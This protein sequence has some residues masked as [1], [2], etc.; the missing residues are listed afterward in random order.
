M[1]TDALL[2]FKNVSKAFG[3]VQANDQVSFSVQTG[4]IHALVGENGAGK[5]TIMKMLFGLYQR[6]RGQIFLN[7][8]SIEFES[9]LQAKRAGIGMVHQHFMLAGPLTALDHI[10]LDDFSFSS[11]LRPLPKKK[12][13]QVLESLSEKYG[14][15]VPWNEKIQNLSVGFQQRI[16]IL[17][18]LHKD[19]KI[20]ILDEPTAVLTPQEVKSL[21]EQLRQLKKSGHTILLITHK[22]KEVLELADEVSVFRQGRVI[23]SLPVNQTSALQLSEWM[24]GRKLMPLQRNASQKLTN[25]FEMKELSHQELKLRNLN[26]KIQGG[27][28][29]GIAGV[30]GNGQ[31]ELLQVLLNPRKFTELQGELLWRDQSLLSDSPSDLKNKGFSYL[32]EDRLAQGALVD[33]N[34]EENFILGRETEPEFQK[35]GFLKTSQ[36]R[37]STEAAIQSFDV[38]PTNSKSQFSHLSGGNQQKLVAAREFSRSPQFLI[39]AQPTRG[40]DIGA[41]ERLH[42]EILKWRDQGSPVLLISSDLEE[43]MKL[44]DRILVMFEGRFVGELAAHQ[45]DEMKIGQWMTG[46]HL[47]ANL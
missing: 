13:L 1:A 43:V 40:V 38:R 20:L 9:P 34:L 4:S 46:A 28:V 2:E 21:F 22:L 23:Q 42:S 47:E 33:F 39:A 41:I 12:K 11:L 32:P 36:I 3:A 10:F 15:P 24:I 45:F 14:M 25:Q 16:E 27:E 30:E 5:S 6:D 31:S 8:E 29:V 17:K 35:N 7:G 44:S 37:K 18:L 19:S 26:L